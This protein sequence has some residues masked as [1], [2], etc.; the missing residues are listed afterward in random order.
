MQAMKKGPDLVM[1]IV[2]V[3][4]VGTVATG[5]FSQADFEL[6]SLVAQ[7]LNK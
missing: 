6:T 4:V 5:L 1:V 3:F 7:V 2:A